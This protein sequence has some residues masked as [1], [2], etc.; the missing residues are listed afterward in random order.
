MHQVIIPNS[1]GE[2]HISDKRP[3]MYLKIE[4]Y[5]DSD[6][7]I[8]SNYSIDVHKIIGLPF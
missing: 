5:N 8:Y 7:M 2:Y 6:R 1:A 3:D 4:D